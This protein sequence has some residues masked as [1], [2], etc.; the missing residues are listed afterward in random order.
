VTGPAPSLKDVTRPTTTLGPP[1]D[2]TL[3]QQDPRRASDTSTGTVE[4][5]FDPESAE[6][7]QHLGHLGVPPLLSPR[8]AAPRL[9][10]RMICAGAPHGQIPEFSTK[11]H[12]ACYSSEQER[13]F[14]TSFGSR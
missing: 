4:V 6:F 1:P 9:D 3:A 5:P 7:K 13:T 11:H 10:G 8:P 14:S 2:I 12:E